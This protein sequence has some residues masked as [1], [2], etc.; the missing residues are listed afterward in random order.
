MAFIACEFGSVSSWRQ[1]KKKG[2]LKETAGKK[3]A[4]CVCII[5]WNHS[6]CL[7][8]V[9]AFVMG[10]EK[11]MALGFYLEFVY[12]RYKLTLEYFSVPKHSAV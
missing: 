9:L 1:E 3:V 10:P 7:S 8:A 12:I 11:V 2:E 5:Q 6:S 4:L